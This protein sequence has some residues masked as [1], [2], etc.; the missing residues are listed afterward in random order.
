MNVNE[1]LLDP[2]RLCQGHVKLPK[3]HGRTDLLQEC[4]VAFNVSGRCT[5]SHVN[6]YQMKHTR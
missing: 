5:C 4:I 1:I 2:P 6:H 3:L